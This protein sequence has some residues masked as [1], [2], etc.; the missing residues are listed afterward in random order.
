MFSKTKKKIVLS[1]MAAL[2]L[3]LAVTLL[4]VYAFSFLSVKKQN[5]EMLDRYVSMYSLESQP[6]SQI[7]AV[8]SGQDEY[9]NADEISLPEEGFPGAPEEGLL[10]PSEGALFQ[11]STFYSAAFSAEGE[12]LAVDTG[13]QGIYAEKE[14]CEFAREILSRGKS[15][16]MSD[17]LL[18]QVEKREEYTLV[19]FMDLTQTEESMHT[20]L[21]NTLLAGVVAAGI[22]FFV[23]IFLANM[24]VKPLEEHDRKEKQFISDAGHE[25]KT[26]VAVISAN[27]EL[28]EREIGNNEWLTN[29]RYENERMGNLVGKMLKLS[30]AENTAF[31]PEPIDLSLLVE[32][33]VLPFEGIAFEH[34]MAIELNAAEKIV[35]NGNEQELGQL[36]SILTDNAIS[37]GTG[38]SIIYI[39]LR[40]DHRQ[41]LLTVKNKAGEIPEAERENVFDRFFRTDESHGDSNGHYGLGLPIAKAITVAHKGR[42]RMD[43]ENGMVIMT[44]RLPLGQSK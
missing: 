44:V 34:D 22:L 16:G 23:S 2:L 5:T 3:F 33:E 1:I 32:R 26:P 30:R 7:P 40:K 13:Q 17:R 27:A 38:N 4:S 14:I 18:Y 31:T 15:D 24:I 12:V 25:L 19:A 6:G 43:W 28:L 10:P 35:V 42:I 37:H 41:A 8:P 39:D 9:G 21:R 11:L 29:I 36:I 20:L